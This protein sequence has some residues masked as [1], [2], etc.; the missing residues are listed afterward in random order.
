MTKESH[1]TLNDKV[2]LAAVELVS[3]ETIRPRDVGNV[4]ER[5]LPFVAAGFRAPPPGTRTTRAR[6]AKRKPARKPRARSAPRSKTK[7]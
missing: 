1:L 6:S 4:V 7:A 2:L 3:G 5:L